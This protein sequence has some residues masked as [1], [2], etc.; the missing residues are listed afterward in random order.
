MVSDGVDQV[1]EKAVEVKAKSE[2]LRSSAGDLAGLSDTMTELVS[3]F[4]I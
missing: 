1:K 2:N 3:R 4:K